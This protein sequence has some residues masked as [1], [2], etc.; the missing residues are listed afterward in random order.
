[1][2]TPLEQKRASSRGVYFDKRIGKYTAQIRI[3]GKRFYLGA[4]EN[5]DDAAA[6]HAL[7]RHDNP[8]RRGG[9]GGGDT[10]AEAWDAFLQYESETTGQPKGVLQAEVEF[11]APSGQRY[12]L[13]KVDTVRHPTHEKVKWVYYRWHSNC[14]ECGADFITSTMPS[15][16]NTGMARACWKH[17]KKGPKLEEPVAH[18]ALLNDVRA[19]KRKQEE[20]EREQEEVDLAV[21]AVIK[22]PGHTRADMRAARDKARAAIA[23]RK[24]AAGGLI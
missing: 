7:A 21:E 18:V 14:S 2:Q 12:F 1:M 4:F 16:R 11:T 9:K 13:T 5:E 17:R 6:A 24:A 10:F 19:A 3:A 22:I 8:I 23:A 15:K 20:A